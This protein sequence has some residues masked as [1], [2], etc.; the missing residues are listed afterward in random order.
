MPATLF[1]A[2]PS[3]GSPLD[4]ALASSPH[5]FPFPLPPSFL[6]L[7]FRKV[8]CLHGGRDGH[9]DHPLLRGCNL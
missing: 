6:F 1:R 7:R 3:L 2:L 8:V 5:S 9:P 4:I